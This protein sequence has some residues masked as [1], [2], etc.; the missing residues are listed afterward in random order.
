MKMVIDGVYLNVS[1]FTYSYNEP[2]NL[3]PL[4]RGAQVQIQ[5]YVYIM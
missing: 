2:E 1:K 3:N 4:G 5:N